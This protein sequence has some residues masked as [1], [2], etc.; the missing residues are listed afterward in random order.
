MTTVK[1]DNLPDVVGDELVDAATGE[2]MTAV[3]YVPRGEGPHPAAI[4][5]HGYPGYA[6]N[7]DLATEFQNAGYA[8][9]VFHYR[10]TWGSE[11]T[12]SLS[13]VL[14]DVETALAAVRAQAVADVDDGSR[15]PR[16]DPHRILLIG[17]SM[18]G[19][20]AL[21]TAA[22]HPGLL[23]AA[24]IAGF[25]FASVALDPEAR[26]WMAKF[27]FT[28]ILPIR[29]L[30]QDGMFADLDAHADEW[31]FPNLAPRL[32]DV[33]LAL[34]GGAADAVAPP[35]AHL[36]PL[37]QALDAVPGA[38]VQTTLLPANHSFA[39]ARRDLAQILL[40]WAARIGG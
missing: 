16:I 15:R 8:G 20:A 38:R 14:R 19:F 3:W 13:G 22:A 11:G 7:D 24:S 29:R 35:R 1:A 2:R 21:Q 17:H 23:G 9:L 18:G 28:G 37:V 6:S 40:A 33:P 26:A 30:E 34:I 31:A 27:L 5:L 39:G 32:H 25:D 4:F 36:D 12:M 10:G